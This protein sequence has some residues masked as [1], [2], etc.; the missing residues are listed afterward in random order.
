MR[1]EA[2]NC[3]SLTGI[4]G[5][6]TSNEKTAGNTRRGRTRPDEAEVKIN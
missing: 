6:V 4:N 2:K 5:F 3:S 1:R